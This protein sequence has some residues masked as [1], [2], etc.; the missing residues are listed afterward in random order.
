L[1]NQQARLA[2]ARAI[3]KSNLLRA[4]A[5][6]AATTITAWR[7]TTV[8]LPQQ[9]GL[10]KV[11]SA[12]SLDPESKIMMVLDCGIDNLPEASNG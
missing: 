7:V 3:A 1:I 6:V 4:V 9:G 2:L 10:T 11:A 12:R 5:G 8:R